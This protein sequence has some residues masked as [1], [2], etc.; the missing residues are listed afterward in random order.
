MA[1]I[2]V[3]QQVRAVIKAAFWN[4]IAALDTALAPLGY[5]ATDIPMLTIARKVLEKTDGVAILT[6]GALQMDYIRKKG[7]PNKQE[8]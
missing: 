5:K 4:E 2:N 8:E 1:E 3:H 7:K 6:P